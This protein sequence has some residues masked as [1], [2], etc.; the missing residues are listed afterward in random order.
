M[1]AYFMRGTK[2]QSTLQR[3]ICADEMHLVSK[4]GKEKSNLAL[5]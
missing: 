1:L 2:C 4:H 3:N 5:H